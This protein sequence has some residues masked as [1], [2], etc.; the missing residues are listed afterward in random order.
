MAMS[1]L[2]KND[3]SDEKIHRAGTATVSDSNQMMNES[4]SLKQ[5]S[6]RKKRKATT[7]LAVGASREINSVV[8]DP[9]SHVDARDERSPIAISAPGNVGIHP[10]DEVDTNDKFA[11][12]FPNQHMPLELIPPIIPEN[13]TGKPSLRSFCSSYP[14]PKKQR[15][16]GRSA[17]VPPADDSGAQV[18]GG[19]SRAPLTA[20]NHI[21]RQAPVQQHAGPVVQIVNGAIV[22][23]ESSIVFHGNCTDANAMLDANDAEAMTVVEEEAEMAV[24]G[25]TYTS[26][27]TGRRARPKVSH[28]TVD[29]TH[30]FYEALRQVGLD[31]GTMEA[32]FESSTNPNIR[33]RLRRQLKRKY[34]AECSK[35]PA[36]IEK[37]LQ[38][39]GR[40]S[41]DLSVFQLTEK[42]IQEL[43]NEREQRSNSAALQE[44]VA[45]SESTVIDDGVVHGSYANNNFLWPD[46][47]VGDD[48]A[49]ENAD[50]EDTFGTDP[51]FLEGSG[52][53]DDVKELG[54][55]K[56][57]VERSVS[58]KAKRPKFRSAAR[59]KASNAK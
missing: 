25:A 7:V 42:L 49:V 5:R 6:Q 39:R 35:N 15:R 55:A 36:L 3:Y 16:T 14:K 10:L 56:I 52:D 40:V 44:A 26:F 48:T 33:K 37:A 18:T 23:Q 31:F 47:P 22:L 54:R 46:A 21:A 13:T 19:S 2:E 45:I 20:A 58:T 12:A 53:T 41:I 57:V 59:K 28:W 34:Q 27:A 29:E 8:I 43:D 11:M 1:F 30:L 9:V 17:A 50:A 51:I 32:Y 24:V 4:S 38:P